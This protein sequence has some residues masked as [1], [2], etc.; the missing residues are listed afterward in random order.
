M[1]ELQVKVV[2]KRGQVPLR[3]ACGDVCHFRSNLLE[4]RTL[5]DQSVTP[6]ITPRLFLPHYRSLI[7]IE[8]PQKIMF[9][10]GGGIIEE[11]QMQWQ[12]E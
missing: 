8:R 9:F 10:G 12:N 4:I 2:T 1:C 6:L 7:I 11:Q 3:D 5:I